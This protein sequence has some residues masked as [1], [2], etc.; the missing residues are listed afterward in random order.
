MGDAA[1]SLYMIAS[2]EVVCHR[3]GGEEELM[4]ISASSD[5]PFFGEACLEGGDA[6]RHAHVV[7]VGSVRCI[8]VSAANFQSLLG[9]LSEV[10]ARNFNAKVLQGIALFKDAGASRAIRAQ[11]WRN[12]GAPPAFSRCRSPLHQQLDHQPSHLLD[13]PPAPQA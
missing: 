5:Q 13:C 12:S 6:T 3:S 9:S 7:A 11:F 4:R 10:M 8:K 1:D 2:G